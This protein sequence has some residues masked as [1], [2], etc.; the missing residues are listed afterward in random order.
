MLG[1]IRPLA[2]VL[3]HMVAENDI[4]APV[5]VRQLDP[6][7][8]SKT[9]SRE[10]TALIDHIDGIDV[11]PGVCQAT[12]M[13][14]DRSRTRPDFKQAQRAAGVAVERKESP[15]LLRLRAPAGNIQ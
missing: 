7:H 13:A 9:V 10:Y 2:H 5:F 6:G 15:D 14:C 1:L 3:E 11:E 12:E 8:E 4:E